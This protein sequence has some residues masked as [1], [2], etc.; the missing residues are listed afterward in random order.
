MCHNAFL[1]LHGIGR[2]KQLEM[3]QVTCEGNVKLDLINYQMM[4]SPGLLYLLIRIKY[5]HKQAKS[6][7]GR[8]SHDSVKDTKKKFL[9]LEF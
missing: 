6:L 3:H 1:A 5:I 7:K 4:L 8:E 9:T 2:G